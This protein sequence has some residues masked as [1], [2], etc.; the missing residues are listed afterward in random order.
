ML[1]ILMLT[2]LL[3]GPSDLG[4]RPRG[5]GRHAIPR[6]LRTTR[7]AET[8]LSHVL[9]WLLSRTHG[10]LRPG[11]VPAALHSL[12]R[13]PHRLPLGKTGMSCR[14]GR[15]LSLWIARRPGRPGSL[16]VTRASHR[17]RVLSHPQLRL[18]NLCITD[19]SIARSLVPS[20][21]HSPHRRAV[22]NLW[23]SVGVHLPDLWISGWKSGVSQLGSLWITFA[24]QT[25]LR[26]WLLAVL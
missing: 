15:T 20:F 19:I 22:H 6:R 16:R 4:P 26:G 24:G 23:I 10:S 13:C 18:L 21:I 5:A 3:A 12:A 7:R 25:C 14:P 9:S 2:R 8:L 11:T 1:L 17:S